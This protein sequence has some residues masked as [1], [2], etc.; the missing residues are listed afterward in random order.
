MTG[1]FDRLW[2]EGKTIL[3]AYNTDGNPEYVGEADAGTSSDATG[4]R[5]KKITYEDGNPTNVEWAD[6]NTNNDNIWDDRED[7][8]YS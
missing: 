5:I 2:V 7:Y 8:T 4:W 1:E 6:G 3:I